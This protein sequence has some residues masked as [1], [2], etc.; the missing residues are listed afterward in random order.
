M[1]LCYK[2]MPQH[3]EELALK[4]CSSPHIN[5]KPPWF[6]RTKQTKQSKIKWSYNTWPGKGRKLQKTPSRLFTQTELHC[7]VF[8]EFLFGWCSSKFQFTMRTQDFFCSE[9][10][11]SES[12]IWAETN[13]S[14][15]LIQSPTTVLEKTFLE[16]ES[17]IQSYC[18]CFPLQVDYYGLV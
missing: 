12:K 11:L 8:R 18:F 14:F 13:N 5:S 7:K 15:H 2:P 9:G 10:K 16:Y 4:K 3:A 6:S 1:L 17:F